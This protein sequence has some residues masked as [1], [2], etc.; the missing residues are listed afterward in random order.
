MAFSQVLSLPLF[1]QPPIT[2]FDPGKLT[3]VQLVE[4]LRL[5]AATE[6]F[7]VIRRLAVSARGTIAVPLVQDLQ[8]RLY[9][10]QGKKVGTIG[11]K[12][13][14]PG[15]FQHI[16]AVSWLR[17]TLVASDWSQHRLSYF[18]PD[19]KLIRSTTF[20]TGREAFARAKAT[21]TVFWNFTPRAVRTDAS[22]IGEALLD[23][24]P[25]PSGK[26][27]ALVLRNAQGAFKLIATV[28]SGDD[29]RWMMWLDGFGNPVP[30]ALAPQAHWGSDGSRIAYLVADQRKDPGTFSVAVRDA[31]GKLTYDRTFSF[32][33]IPIPA[34]VADSAISATFPLTIAPPEGPPNSQWRTLAR[35]RV[36]ATL[37]LVERVVIGSDGRAWLTLRAT[38]AGQEVAVLDERGTPSMIARLPKGTR[39]E[40]ASATHIWATEQDADG[41]TSVVRYRIAK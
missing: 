21:D 40:Q 5:D 1:A 28:P 30:F 19:A 10:A 11:R 17:D 26:S 14:G 41:L 8:I 6:D 9:D 38:N 13:A 22:T 31:A 12:G 2:S 7:S 27:T 16:S 20:T 29:D 32:K 24:G 15:E 34:A 35:K 33:R 23:V 3:R 39:I 37:S 4:E 25:T 18:G 36:P